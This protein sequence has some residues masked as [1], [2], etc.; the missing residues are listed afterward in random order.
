[1]VDG[2]QIATLVITSCILLLLFAVLW[3]RQ[4]SSMSI[5]ESPPL[6]LRPEATFILEQAKKI[7]LG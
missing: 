4:K 7:K 6:D 3:Q 2:I 5:D 1:M